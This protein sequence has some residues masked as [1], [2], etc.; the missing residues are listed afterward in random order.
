LSAAPIGVEFPMR[1]AQ[2]LRLL[3]MVDPGDDTLKF[4]RA[5]RPP[6]F[7]EP[8]KDGIGGISQFPGNAP[9]FFPRLL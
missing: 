8:V 9:D 7:H 3:P 4:S 2:P 1:G 6:V 5:P